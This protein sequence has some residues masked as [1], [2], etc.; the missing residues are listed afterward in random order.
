M[1][2]TSADPNTKQL[3]RVESGKYCVYAHLVAGAT[4]YIGS[5]TASRPYMRTHRNPKW[6]ELTTN[7]FDVEILGWFDSSPAASVVEKEKI[8]ELQPE[9]N[10]EGS[11]R[12]QRTGA[13]WGGPRDRAG[14]PTSGRVANVAVIP[15]GVKLP[16][17]VNREAI[18][19]LA[20]LGYS[21]SQV[22]KMLK[23]KERSVIRA[24]QEMIG[25]PK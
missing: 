2:N 1:E 9:A 23:I 14:R 5:G 16:P 18:V 15:G 3:T 7:G 6:R 13:N 4:I 21:P 10:R 25:E 20:K 17:R 12:A 22:A 24:Y 19:T 11:A 8:K